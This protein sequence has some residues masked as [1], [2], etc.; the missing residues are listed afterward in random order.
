MMLTLPTA[1]IV[2]VKNRLKAKENIFGG[3]KYMTMMLKIVPKSIIGKDKRMKFALAA[4]NVGMGHIYD[5][6]VLAKRL[7]KDPDSWIDIREILPL[8]TQKKYYRTLKYGY[9]RGAEP[10]KYVD[11][12]SEYANILKQALN[13]QNKSLP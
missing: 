7:H 3:A 11:G 1:K 10:V 9:A 12:I 13:K 5:A 2:G 8:L 4:Y 6:R